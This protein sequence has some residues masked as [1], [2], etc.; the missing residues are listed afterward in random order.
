MMAQKVSIELV[1]DLDGT[2]A[3]ETVTF[4]LDGASY[5]I[6]LNT[7]NATKLRKALADF[8]GA[9]RK[10]NGKRQTN[11]K[12]PDVD[13]KAVR[14]WAID[15]GYEISDRGRVPVDVVEAYKAAR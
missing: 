15:N 13:T 3:V 12:K 7:K 6:D 14:A 9:G 2:V 4:G 11:G 10:V 5:E 8:V 1:D